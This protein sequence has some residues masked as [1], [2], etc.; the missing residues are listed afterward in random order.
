MDGGLRREEPPVG[1]HHAGEVVAAQAV[2]EPVRVLAGRGGQ[3]PG[4]QP[5]RDAERRR[6][7]RADASSSMLGHLRTCH[8]LAAGPG[9]EP[10]RRG[11]SATPLAAPSGSSSHAHVVDTR[12]H[13]LLALSFQRRQLP[14]ESWSLD[15]VGLDRLSSAVASRTAQRWRRGSCSRIYEDLWSLRHRSA[16]RAPQPGTQLLIV[17]TL[18]TSRPAAGIL[19]RPLQ[20]AKAD[21]PRRVHPLQADA[22][23]ATRPPPGARSAHCRLSQVRLESTRA[24]GTDEMPRSC[25]RLDRDSQPPAEIA[26]HARRD[27]Y[28]PQRSP[29]RGRQG[30]R[31]TDR[32]CEVG[33][34]P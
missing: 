24:Q 6:A 26:G 4:A 11:S 34:L 16:A 31:R 10:A 8:I 25:R 5:G 22:A 19:R 12:H 18:H 32:G 33:S 17:V 9:I 2:E 21:G 1:H 20:A 14:G 28:R 29:R 13:L 23:Q 15:P 30:R 3:Q 27:A 7:D